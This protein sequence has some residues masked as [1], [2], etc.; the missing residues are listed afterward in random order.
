[1]RESSAARPDLLPQ[2]SQSATS[3]DHLDHHRQHDHGSDRDLASEVFTLVFTPR[4]VH[5]RCSH[6]RCVHTCVHTSPCSQLC[7]QLCSHLC[8]H[9]RSHQRSQLGV[10]NLRSVDTRRHISMCCVIVITIMIIMIIIIVMITI[11]ATG[12]PVALERLSS[13]HGVTRVP[14]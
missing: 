3:R 14:A 6:L 8:S 10:F 4:T 7:S 1:M 2:R 9:Q 5:S 12:M 11:N 13:D